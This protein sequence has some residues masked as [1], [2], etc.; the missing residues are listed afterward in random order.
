M[1]EISGMNS[2]GDRRVDRRGLMTKSWQIFILCACLLAVLLFGAVPGD[3]PLQ[4]QIHP[5]T[6]SWLRARE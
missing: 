3:N 2:S 6:A 5:M 1:N 4:S